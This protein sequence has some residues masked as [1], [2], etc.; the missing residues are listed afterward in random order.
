MVVAQLFANGLWEDVIEPLEVEEK[1]S[2]GDEGRKVPLQMSE[3]EFRGVL[4]L[5]SGG[6]EQE[7]EPLQVVTG[8]ESD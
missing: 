6:V 4:S 7:E 5:V 8:E 2:K 1:G 3:G